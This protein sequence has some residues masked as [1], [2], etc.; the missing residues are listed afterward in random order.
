M[1][2]LISLIIITILSFS[3]I[4]CEEAKK[5]ENVIYDDLFFTV[6]KLDDGKVIILPHDNN[7]K[8]R[9]IVITEKD[10]RLGKFNVS[11]DK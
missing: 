3:F 9:P 7:N 11:I 10:Y 1:N 5:N 8:Q 2:K 6:L 4:S